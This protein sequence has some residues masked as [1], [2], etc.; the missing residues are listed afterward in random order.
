MKSFQAAMK[1]N[2][3]IDWIPKAPIFLYHSSADD[4]VP[5][6]NSINAYNSFKKNSSAT[7][8]TDFADHVI[9]TVM[10]NGKPLNVNSGIIKNWGIETTYA[11]RLNSMFNITGNYSFLHMKNPVT[12]APKHKFYMIFV[13]GQ[14]AIKRIRMKAS[15]LFIPLYIGFLTS[16]ALIGLY[17][18]GFVLRLDNVFNA[19]Y[20]IPIF[21]IIMG[22]MLSSNVIALNAYY[23]GLQREQQLYRY[24]LGNGA[25]RFEAQ[26]PF[27]RSAMVRKVRILLL[28]SAL[29]AILNKLVPFIVVI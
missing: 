6:V 26:I 19:R 10:T 22:N 9:E 11:Y 23:D 18:L 15:V 17:F 1:K 16:V 12:A 21:G 7:I 28:E 20:F 2:S 3:L 24:L 29:N 25:G 4:V 27:I 5:Q 13:A 8:T 14:T